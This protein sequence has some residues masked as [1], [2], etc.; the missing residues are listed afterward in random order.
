MT[1]NGQTYISIPRALRVVGLV[2]GIWGTL[3][4]IVATLAYLPEHPGFSPFT[5]YL[6]DIGDTPGWPQV[7]FNSGTLIAAPMR[8]LV[9]VLLVLRLAQLGAGRAF[10][11]SA[12]IVSFV[13]TAGTVLM[14]AVPFSVGPAVHKWGIGLY[15]LGVVVLQA[16]ISI[17]E[18]SLKDVPKALPGLSLLM[19]AVFVVFATLVILYEQ[20]MVSRGAP[21]IWEWLCFVTSI[22]WV[23]A[24]SVLLG[25]E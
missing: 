6:S 23:F 8:F 19:V 3:V 21:V 14:T 5:T 13:S 9:I 7:L 22:V 12:L 20:G 17:R 4:V 16:L 25:K 18:W 10:S 24:H 1:D 2:A 15:F 11:I